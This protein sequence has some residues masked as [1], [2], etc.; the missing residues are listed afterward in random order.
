MKKFTLGPAEDHRWPQRG[1]DDTQEGNRGDSP[2]DG[3]WLLHQLCCNLEPQPQPQESRRVDPSA[4][5]AVNQV[6]P[7]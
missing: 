3:G 6:H 7:G 5:A 2:Y 4:A 1:G